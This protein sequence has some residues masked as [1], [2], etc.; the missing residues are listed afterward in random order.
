[1]VE[2][3]SY[4]FNPYAVAPMMA[5]LSVLVFAVVVNLSE[6]KRSMNADLNRL[7][8]AVALWLLG[9]FALYSAGS[10]QAAVPISR[11]AVAAAWAI[12]AAAYAFSLRLLRI[13]QPRGR[14][15]VWGISAVLIVSSLLTTSVVAGV[16]QHFWG[17][18]PH[19]G[20]GGVLGLVFSAAVAA[21]VLRHYL[22]ALGRVRRERQRKRIELFL[23]ANA[24]G[25]LALV[26]AIPAFG[27]PLFPFGFMA[28]LV[29]VLFGAV[30]VTRYRLTEF[31]PQF[32][33]QQILETMQGSVLVLDL[34]GRI[35][36][37]NRA[38]AELLG[39]SDEEFSG[40][41]MGT[42]IE[43][44][45]NVGSAS[46]TLMRGGVVRDRAMVWKRKDG[47]YAEVAVSGSLLRDEEGLP[48]GI[49]YVALDISDRRRAE[50]IEYQAFHDALTGLPNRLLFRNR[51]T[52]EIENDAFDGSQVTAMVLDLDGFKRV[53][54]TFGHPV[55]DQVLQS[56]ARRLRESIKDRDSIAR[57]GGDEFGVLVRIRSTQDAPKIAARVLSALAR[58]FLVEGHELFI[59]GSIGVANHPEDGADAEAL[60]RTAE[61]AMYIA[62]ELG[63]NRY[64]MGG[65]ALAERSR[66]RL[67]MES[68]LRRAIDHEQLFLLYQPI[69]S[70]PTGRV[71]GVEALLRWKH[72]TRGVLPPNDFVGIAEE[73]GLIVPMGEWV[74][75]RACADAK[76]LHL[77]GFPEVRIAV[78]LSPYQFQQG[79]VV[80]AV[81][82]ALAGSSLPPSSLQVELTESAA[83]QNAD[84]A[85]AALRALRERGVHVAID[86]FGTGYSSLAYLKRFPIDTVKLDQSFV[87][88]VTSTA[89]D[90]AIVSA[91]IAMAHA[92]N[93]KV[94]AEGVETERQLAVLSEMECEEM[95]GF[96]VS[97]PLPFDSLGAFL[98]NAPQ[99]TPFDLTASTRQRLKLVKPPR[100]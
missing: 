2:I 58:P 23:G 33:A 87:R 18:Y 24:I 25:S 20:A 44:P 29:A 45:L 35:R 34:G 71:T 67:F 21:W 14:A 68:S 95:Q 16:R 66:E 11:F 43:S 17:H 91:V 65:P 56:A 19:F 46:D 85:V 60:I 9:L 54:E 6:R 22:G 50:Q 4:K 55:G 80:E 5:A 7:C 99:A 27:V 89:G 93:L 74:L 98:K 8:A 81:E 92:L 69:V 39:Y 26:D 88:D 82:R 53:N 57:L 86:D 96:L 62:K 42:I 75:H 30:A 90:A 32:A 52:Y 38:A 84:A 76:R 83:M 49:V 79:G 63:K 28:V 78:N 40:R 48:Y 36:R 13:E 10:E 12:P 51:L 100:E 59:T 3:I 31:A 77:A 72:P 61:Q 15:V 47:S 97:E 70:I 73:V 37:A 94:V 64:Q 41:D 1:V